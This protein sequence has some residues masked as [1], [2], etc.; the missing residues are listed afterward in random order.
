MTAMKTGVPQ[1]TVDY[2]Q[3]GLNRLPG[4]DQPLAENPIEREEACKTQAS[5][6]RGSFLRD[7]T[8]NREFQIHSRRVI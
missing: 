2:R 4:I 5:L 8:A 1:V 7:L 3:P 6:R